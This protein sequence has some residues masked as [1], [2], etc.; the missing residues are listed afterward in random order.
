MRFIFF[1]A[2]MMFIF[3]SDREIT[4]FKVNSSQ[5]SDDLIDYYMQ[6]EI[7]FFK[8]NETKKDV[9]ISKLNPNY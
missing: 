8:K 3:M 4:E 1:V 5:V 2:L 6:K 9:N 7:D